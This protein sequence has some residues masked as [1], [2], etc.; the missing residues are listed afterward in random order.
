M[1]PVSAACRR[2]LNL[3]RRRKANLSMQANKF[4]NGININIVDMSGKAQKSVFYAIETIEYRV[5]TI[6]YFYY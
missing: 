6:R 2:G 3:L 4:A 5:N 1:P